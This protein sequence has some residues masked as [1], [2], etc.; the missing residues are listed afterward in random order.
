MFFLKVRSDIRSWNMR[1]LTQV[2]APLY[3]SF[4][5]YTIVNVDSQRQL[6]SFNYRWCR[7][8]LRQSP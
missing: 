6:Q 2:Q 7:R 8:S 4:K 1:S 3:I 5:M